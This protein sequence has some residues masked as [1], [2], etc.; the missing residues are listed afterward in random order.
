[1]QSPGPPLTP[2]PASSSSPRDAP[3]PNEAAHHAPNE[4][5]A[6][7]ADD[8]PLEPLGDGEI[9]TPRGPTARPRHIVDR[10]L[11]YLA[12]ARQGWRPRDIAR[13]RRRSKGYVSILLRLASAIDGLAALELEVLRSK[14][15]TWK[16]VQRIVRRDASIPW[17]R[18]QLRLAV[19]GFSRHN[20]DRRKYR[21]SR[22]G[23]RRDDARRA[24]LESTGGG[25]VAWDEARAASDPVAYCDWYIGQLLAVH[26]EFGPR[27][28]QALTA[29]LPN[30]PFSTVPLVGQSLALLMAATTRAAASARRNAG[31]IPAE[32]Q[33][34]LRALAQLDDFFRSLE[35]RAGDEGAPE[36]VSSAIE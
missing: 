28:R 11:E 30:S 25:W 8:A 26:R 32:Q 3:L 6:R 1:M 14:R 13:R 16:L 31:G 18:E 5:G 20:V 22:A 17:I 2:G 7:I 34:A 29:P 15:I 4:Y 33:R 21:G 36:S 24:L 9:G 19:G 35:R 23:R 27:L 12:L 10:A